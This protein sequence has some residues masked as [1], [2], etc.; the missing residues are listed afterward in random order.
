MQRWARPAPPWCTGDPTLLS[1]QGRASP[2]TS[3]RPTF[4]ARRAAY[5]RS[6]CNG[7]QCPPLTKHVRL[8]TYLTGPESSLVTFKQ[9]GKGTGGSFPF[10]RSPPHPMQACRLFLSPT[11]S[12]QR[13]LTSLAAQGVAMRGMG[14]SHWRPAIRRRRRRIISTLTPLPAVSSPPPPPRPSSFT[15]RLSPGLRPRDV[16]RG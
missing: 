5:N 7:G 16:V 15:G 3:P 12:A 14:V 4:A 2:Q 13:R 10:I 6:P 1:G 8:G 11:I 9:R